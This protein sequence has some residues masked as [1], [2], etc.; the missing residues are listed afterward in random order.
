MHCGE[1]AD[2]RP[3]D[4]W[5]RSAGGGLGSG[6]VLRMD[7]SI[8]ALADRAFALALAHDPLWA[9]T[10]GEHRFDDRLPDVS[11][12]G[13]AAQA[14][15]LQALLA[16]VEAVDPVTLDAEDRV[17]HAM[18]R[19]ETS[20]ALDGLA[21]RLPEFVIAPTMVGAHAR[22][23]EAAPRV[24]LPE[25][26]HAEAL[27]D[28]YARVPAYLAQ[29][30][31]RLRTGV[32]AGR[33][34][35]A[36]AVE[37]TIRQLD[38][39]VAAPLEADPLLEPQPPDDWP[40]AH[41]W[42][43]RLAGLV[44]EVVRPALAA[45]RDALAADIAPHARPE[46]RSG[47]AYLP[48][49]GE[50][51]ERER[52]RYTSLVASDP[53]DLHAVGRAEIE[54]LA[55][56]YRRLG[57]AALGTG[58]LT[59]IFARLRDDPALRFSTSAEVQAAAESALR[60]A[61]AAMGGWF[62]RLP[63]APCVVKPMQAHEVESGTIAY[64]E[65][66]AVDGSRPGAYHVNTYA[67]DT[68]TR[69]ESEALAFH[70][71]VPGHH[72][73]IAIAQE[74]DHLPAFRRNA[75]VN[76]YVEGWALYAERLADEMGLYASDVARLGMLAFDSWR[77]GRLVVDTGLHHLGWSRQQAVDYLRDNSPLARNNIDNEVDRYLVWPGQALGYKV[78]QLEIQ[79]LRAA[80]EA[81]LGDRFD[82]RAFHDVVL[83]HGSVPLAVLDDV[84]T[85][86][87]AAQGPARPAARPAPPPGR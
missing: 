24:T 68:R 66:P 80:A 16:D 4:G 14:A 21:S 20:A 41:A 65:P 3:G 51:Y 52:R 57:R 83:G 38:S 6:T 84:V 1:H 32:A 27:L 47:L 44:A 81:A 74:L 40:G 75:L 82:L 23:L 13:E 64:Y 37:Q 69:F 53:D 25:A 58:D 55:A 8:A 72:T 26:A 62:G 11:A 56:E 39:Y 61:E 9:S 30:A 85:G 17:T 45:Y 86:W 19:F 67:P 50:V 33:T 7:A 18:L 87:V 49:G 31:D 29:A 48:D 10:L 59:E 70:E 34:P 54:R 2:C 78:G 63:A 60:R 35:P 42:R 71:A 73:Q 77:A 76:A 12:E 15:E 28:R 36:R 46:E 22:L 43:E 79:R 5:S